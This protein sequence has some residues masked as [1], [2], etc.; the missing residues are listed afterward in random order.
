TPAMVITARGNSHD[1]TSRPAA[2]AVGLRAGGPA[3][4]VTPPPPAWRA[5]DRP[6]PIPGP[7]HRTP[8][9]HPRRCIPPI[10]PAAGRPRQVADWRI[11]ATPLRTGP[12]RLPSVH[13][14]HRS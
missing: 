2:G 10:R 13:T 9:G 14:Q 8:G 1:L 7:P 6:T 5:T 12:P 3:L 11:F 4:I